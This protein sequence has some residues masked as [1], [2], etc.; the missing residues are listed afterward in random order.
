MNLRKIFFNGIVDENPVFRLV[1]GMCPALAITVTALNGIG[2]GAAATFVLVFSNLAISL[3]RKVIPAAIRI[4]AFV[5]VIA[6]FVTI[7]DLLIQAFVPALNR[8]LGIFIP[9]IVVNCLIFARAEAFAF[10]NP[11]LA[12]L[13]DGLGMGV[14]FTLAITILSAFREIFGAGTLLGARVMPAAYQPMSI[15]TQP[16]GGFI[17]LGLLLAAADLITRRKMRA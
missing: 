9:L 2:M 16:P 6:T 4:P 1:L 15:I 5:I 11:P 8:S 14:G 17:M 10:K 7:V 13:V 3:M 12:S